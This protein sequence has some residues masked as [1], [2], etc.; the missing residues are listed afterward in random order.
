MRSP[1]H[2]LIVTLLLPLGAHA[3]PW[4]GPPTR[5]VKPTG[6]LYKQQRLPP[7]VEVIGGST[8]YKGHRVEVA[9]NGEIARFAGGG[10]YRDGHP[11]ELHADGHFFRPQHLHPD[12]RNAELAAKTGTDKKGVYHG[13]YWGQRLPDGVNAHQGLTYDRVG[14][15]IH[16]DAHGDTAELHAG[17]LW[18]DGRRMTIGPQG[19]LLRAQ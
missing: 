3:S 13:T 19:H 5:V 11:V 15:R 6:G 7:K 14:H 8:Y 18:K 16:V 1:P 9:P 2:A 12:W 10:M 17:D 4:K